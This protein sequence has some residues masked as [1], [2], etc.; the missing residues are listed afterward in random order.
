MSAAEA[1]RTLTLGD[2]ERFLRFLSANP[3]QVDLS[4]V[5]LTEMWSLAAL[6][7]LARTDRPNPLTIIW[8]D[9]QRAQ[10]FARAVGLD[11]VIEGQQGAIE[12]EPGRTVRLSRAYLEE[13]I[14]P[15][16]KKIALLLAGE[17]PSRQSARW[18][19]QYVITELLRNVVQHSGDE[20]GAVVGA[21][22]NDR[23]LHYDRPVFQVA[24]AD[25]G[26]G[27]RASLNRSYPEIED[28]EVALERAM[29]PHVSGAFPAGRSGGEEN[30]GLGLFYISEMAKGLSGRMLLSSCTA[31]IVIDPLSPVRQQVL[32][33]GFPG[34][35]VAFEVPAET[36]RDFGQLFDEIGKLAEERTPR[37]LTKHWLR[38][39]PPPPT[40]GKFIVSEFIENNDAANKLAQARLIPRL[41]KKE[42]VALDFINVRVC[43]QSFAHALLYEALRFAWASQ[44]P[45]Y[46]LNAHPVVQSA[47]KHVETYAQTG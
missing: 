16:A 25:A 21:Q 17:V 27:I 47:L 28:D 20:C 36:P 29:W 1:P 46:I 33:V 43:T 38:F 19:M 44:T 24:V 26:R 3:R 23:G 15:I 6:G 42:P 45:I 31:S 30:A 37:R 32:Q 7:A 13:D 10:G 40:V 2:P 8:G 12:G 34:T 35:L 41:V 4:G 14:H 11:D 22:L 18:A 9:N 39:E 5:S